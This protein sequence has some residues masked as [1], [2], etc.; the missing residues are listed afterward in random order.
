MGSACTGIETF[1]QAVSD[2][3]CVFDMV[4]EADFHMYLLDI[5][6]DFPGPEDT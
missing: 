4:T 3:H 2:V 6:G 5:G 1:V